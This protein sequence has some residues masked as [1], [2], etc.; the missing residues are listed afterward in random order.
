[1]KS[2]I[3]RLVDATIVP[4]VVHIWRKTSAESVLNDV[5][6]ES[7]RR[8]VSDVLND[9]GY[10]SMRRAVS[11]SADYVESYMA[12][13]FYMHTIEKLRHH[14]FD[15]RTP[16]GLIVEFGVWTGRSITFLASLTGQTIYGF[17]SFEGL[18]EDWAAAS[19]RGTFDLHGTPPEV[20]A[21]VKLIKG[22]F[23]ETL[24]KF[25]SEHPESFS[26][27]HIDC[28]TYEATSIVL[29][30]AGSR[31]VKGTVVVFDEYFGY[32]GWRMGEFKAWQ[33]F[34]AARGLA[35]KYLAFSRMAVFAGG[36]LKYLANSPRFL[37]S[38]KA[39]ALV[40]VLP[41]YA[42]GRAILLMPELVSSR[43]E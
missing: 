8:A 23:D 27:V 28:D 18:R 37:S 34:V 26:F 19:P 38:D 16:G 11:D 6:Y 30:I 15:A 33:E 21:N 1:M 31:F 9:V 3:K 22:W 25:L 39:I 40:A 12:Q 32:R 14:A 2:A 10:E 42:A 29:K 17:D 36:C 24:P 5:M 7:M 13:T 20:P 43:W 4:L 35:Y 41:G